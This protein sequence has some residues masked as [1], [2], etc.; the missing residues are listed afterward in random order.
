LIDSKLEIETSIL[1]D[2]SFHELSEA[3]L[4]A[5]KKKPSAKT[6]QLVRTLINL[7]G[8]V[9]G[10]ENDIYTAKQV[11]DGYRQKLRGTDKKNQVL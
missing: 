1:F 6:A 4:D 3:I 11:I 2:K 9:A 8:Y 5:H 10:L 7:R